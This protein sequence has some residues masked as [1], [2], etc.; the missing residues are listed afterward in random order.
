MPINS[1]ECA[2]I[3]SVADQFKYSCNIVGVDTVGGD[4]NDLIKYDENV[5]I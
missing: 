4:Q 3:S 2:E 5:E 1:L